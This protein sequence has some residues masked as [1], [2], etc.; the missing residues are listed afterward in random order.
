MTD[1]FITKSGVTARYR[2]TSSQKSKV[3]GR[4]FVLPGFTEFIEKHGAQTKAF[5][6][7]GFDVL[8]MDWIN[9]GLSDRLTPNKRLIHIDDYDDQLDMVLAAAEEAQFLDGDLPIMIFGHSMG[10]HLALRLGRRLYDD[11][12]IKAKGVMLSS[13]MMMPPVLPPKLIYTLLKGVCALGFSRKAV[14]FQQG[15]SRSREFNPKNNLT[16]NPE[17]YTLQHDLIDQNPDLRSSG[18]TFGW[19]KA[20]YESCLKTTGNPEWL[21]DY[22][23]PVNAHIAGNETVVA[24]SYSRPCLSRIQGVKL[25]QYPD[26]KHE[27]MLEMPDVVDAVWARFAEFIDQNLKA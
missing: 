10:G 11:Y 12:G 15:F 1:H 6:D 4:C 19:V 8:T 3:R 9:Q 2:L 26:A 23:L 18:P 22:P 14:P 7:M 17:G 24:A 5:A 13:P 16:R 20:S 25:Y 27:L 21:S